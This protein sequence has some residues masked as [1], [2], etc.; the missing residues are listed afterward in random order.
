MDLKSNTEK[1]YHK[2][3]ISENLPRGQ[4]IYVYLL[5]VPNTCNAQHAVFR[6]FFCWYNN[7]D[8]AA[9]QEAF[10]KHSS[11]SQQGY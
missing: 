1:A 9:T 5:Q 7:K 8:V 4:K 2:L 3:K 6:R 10:K 11:S